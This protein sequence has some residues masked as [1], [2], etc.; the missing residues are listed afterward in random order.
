M[1]LL[2]QIPYICPAFL[3]DKSILSKT[4]SYIF[5]KKTNRTD[6]KGDWPRW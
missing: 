6:L 1:T 5:K 4:E 3:Y 2:I